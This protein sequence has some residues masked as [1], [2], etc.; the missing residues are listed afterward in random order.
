MIHKFINSLG[1]YKVSYYSEEERLIQLRRYQSLSEKGQRHFLGFEYKRLGVGS[2][3]Y[4]SATF[5]CSRKR[6]RRGFREV[7]SSN[8]PCDHGGE[9]KQGGGRKKRD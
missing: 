5:S 2:Q 6:I 3:S 8:F 1:R 4:L 9:R 7:E